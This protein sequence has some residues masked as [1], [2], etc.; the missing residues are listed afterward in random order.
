VPKESL[1]RRRLGGLQCRPGPCGEGKKY[2]V[3]VN[4]KLWKV[5]DEVMVTDLTQCLIFSQLYRAS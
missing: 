4:K 1:L 3:L 5:W 2:P